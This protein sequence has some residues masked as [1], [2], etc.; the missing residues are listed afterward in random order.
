[1]YTGA[2]RPLMTYGA[3][4]WW[5]L[6]KPGGG[7]LAAHPEEPLVRVEDEALREVIGAFRGSDRRKVGW[8]AGVEPVCEIL[9]DLQMRWE[10][11]ALRNG[12]PEVRRAA[13]TAPAE[14]TAPW[15]AANPNEDT[16]DSPISRAFHL[17][18]DAQ[19]EEL[20]W[21]D[22]QDH[23]TSLVQDLTIFEPGDADSKVAAAWA[24]GL[25]TLTE[26][27]WRIAYT[28]GTGGSRKEVEEGERAAGVAAE[29]PTGRGETQYGA[30]LGPLASVADSERTAMALALEREGASWHW[31]R[32]AK[33]P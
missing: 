5:G 8:I 27:G 6:R 13:G 10:A 2:I 9:R 30:Y 21:G 18:G 24:P 32:T 31:H 14:G 12:D 19:P 22:F 33:R 3:E 15:Y 17:L 29:G 7:R 20:S 1:M 4:V 28:D 25:Q 26:R 23:R 11:R 16:L